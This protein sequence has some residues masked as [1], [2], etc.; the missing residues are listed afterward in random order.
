MKTLKPKTL[1]LVLN[2]WP[3]FWAAGIRVI[4]L[5]DDWS[6]AKVRLRKRWYNRNYVN[7]HYGGSLFSMT[8]PFYMLLFL[9][10]MGRNYVVWDK[11][12]EIK[13]IK[14]GRKDVFAEFNIEEQ[15]LDEFKKQL[16]TQSKIEPVF[17]VDI[18]DA[19]GTLIAK[20]WKTLHIAKKKKAAS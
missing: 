3:P 11:K 16:E 6:F 19:D 8:D 14:P 2:L 7:T 12:S 9:H 10:Q 20:V 4:E 15:Q 1:K 5:S 18:I 13:F 17:E